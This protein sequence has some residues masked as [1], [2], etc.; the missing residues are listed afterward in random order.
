MGV[1]MHE[2]QMAQ[3]HLKRASRHNRDAGRELAASGNLLLLCKM[4]LLDRANPYPPSF[5]DQE[6][7]LKTMYDLESGSHMLRNKISQA[8]L[9]LALYSTHSLGSWKCEE[10]RQD[11]QKLC[12]DAEGRKE[13]EDKRE[14][15][16]H[17]FPELF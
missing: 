15:A 10:A 9:L 3:Y 11:L 13:C 4:Q 14:E 2:W 7:E 16:M 5:E 17:V 8:I 12:K 6:Q 1:Q